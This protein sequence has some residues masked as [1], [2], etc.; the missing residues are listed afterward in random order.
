MEIK[1]MKIKVLALQSTDRSANSF[2]CQTRGPV[3]LQSKDFGQRWSWLL[4]SL[5][6]LLQTPELPEKFLLTEAAVG[7]AASLITFLGL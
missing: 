4:P 5:F 2:C 3:L 6:H 1:E 7:S